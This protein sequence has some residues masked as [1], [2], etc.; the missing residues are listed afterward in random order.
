VSG[1]IMLSPPASLATSFEVAAR[2][3]LDVVFRSDGITEPMAKLWRRAEGGVA[4]LRSA[5]VVATM[6]ST[7]PGAVGLLLA[8]VRAGVRLVSLPLPPRGAGAAAYPSFLLQTL[9]AAAAELVVVDEE[10]LRLL[11]S[12]SVP[13]M[14]FNDLLSGPGQEGPGEGFELLQFSSGT[15]GDPKGVL[16]SESSITNNLAA[17]LDRISPR[18][19]QVLVSW[20]PLSH[21][22]GLIGAVMTS[23]FAFDAANVRDGELVLIRP[24]QFVRNPR[25]WLRACSE[26]R[27]TVTLAPD[28]GFRRVLHPPI[29]ELDLSWLEVCLTGAE[30]IRRDTLIDVANVLGLL[31]LSPKAICPAYGCAEATLAISISEPATAWRTRSIT[32]P[33]DGSDRGWTQEVVSSGPPLLGTEVVIDADDGRIGSVRVRSGSLLSQYSDGSSP[34]DSEGWLHTN[35]LGAIIDGELH[36]VG[37][38]DDIVIA[39]GR[40]LSGVRIREIVE[41]VPGVRRGTV[42]A[43]SDPDDSGYL[44]VFEAL[45]ADD[46]EMGR[47]VWTSLIRELPI[48]PNGIVLA[49]TG[50]VPRTPSGK[51]RRYL[52]E[53]AI[54]NG[55]GGFHRLLTHAQK[56]D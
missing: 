45:A 1:G 5:G 3:P 18:E 7:T 4:K 56:R 13:V 52:V 21:D 20:L 42:V 14:T 29:E 9:D 37:R 46:T 24:Q 15:T 47:R 12:L 48:G 40:N 28:F 38:E 23:L 19:R 51:P 35:D 54:A 33:E 11:P 34:V 53:R 44:V 36:I 10:I 26:H 27:A 31:G 49:E 55:A 6:L 43:V 8:S 2:S 41:L 32:V 16:L 39:A 50:A 25:D 30:P 17:I 22:M